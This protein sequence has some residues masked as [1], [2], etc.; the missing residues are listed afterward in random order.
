[1][2]RKRNWVFT[3]YELDATFTKWEAD[4]IPENVRY[5]VYQQEICPD[6]NRIHI[7]GYV[8]F[9]KSTRINSVKKILGSRGIHLESRKGTAQEAADYCKK[10]ET[11]IRGTLREYGQLSTIQQGRRSDLVT[12]G[13][14]LRAG[15]EIK[16]IADDFPANY[17]RY[18]RGIES[19]YCRYRRHAIPDWRTVKVWTI[20]GATGVGKTRTVYELFGRSLFTLSASKG[21]RIW[22]DGYEGEETLLIDEFYG[23]LPYG[24]LLQLLDGYKVRLPVKGGHTYSAWT[25]VVIT[26]NNEPTTWYQFGVTPALERRLS[27]G[28]IY[29]AEGELEMSIIR[30]ILQG[31]GEGREGEER[32]DEEV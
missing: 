24:M 16:Q 15:D 14:R 32:V 20:W 8:E 12:I 18:S 11:A 19:L 31:G 26:S 5:I 21:E 22:F 28:G 30:L 1:M 7:Q 6:T 4:T 25:S 17:I 10:S 3:C 2:S 23:W 9:R 29:H 27:T 13:E